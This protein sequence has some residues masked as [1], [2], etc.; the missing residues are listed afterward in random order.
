MGAQHLTRRKSL[1]PVASS[2]AAHRHVILIPEADKF[3][4][5]HLTIEVGDLVTWG[6]ERHRRPHD[7]R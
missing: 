3:V 2:T 4:P 6:Q 1:L 7:R 5:Y